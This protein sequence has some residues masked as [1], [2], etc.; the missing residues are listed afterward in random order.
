MEKVLLVSDCS[1]RGVQAA[2][3]IAELMREM[4]FHP[5]TVGLIINRAPNGELDAGTRAEMEKQGLNLLGVIPQ[6]D[7]V[8]RFDCDG[9][10]MVE[11][12]KDS[13]VRRALGEIIAKLG[14]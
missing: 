11:L 2:G 10:P 9:R 4:N 6:D 14:I 12:P 5:D 13:P 1:R 8:Y 7:M 3:R